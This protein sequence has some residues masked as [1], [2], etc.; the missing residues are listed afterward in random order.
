MSIKSQEN[1]MRH[2]ADLLSHDLGYVFGEK[3]CGPNGDKKTFLNMGKVFLRA[4][5]KDL[6]FRESLV[7]SNPAGIGVS[8]SVSLYGMWEGNGIYIC[9]EQLFGGSENVV[10]FRTIRDLRDHKGG[11][12]HFLSVNDLRSLSYEELLERFQSLRKDGQPYEYA[13]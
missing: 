9:L 6:G 10:L 3:E 4:M 7:T 2:L 13:A 1:N 8:G 11:Y 5:A 12:N